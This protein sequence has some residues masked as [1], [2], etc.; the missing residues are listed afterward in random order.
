MSRSIFRL[1][2]TGETAGLRACAGWFQ[3]ISQF[4]TPGRDDMVH[5]LYRDIFR[6]MTAAAL[7]RIAP[8]C[9][10]RTTGLV[11]AFVVCLGS[12]AVASQKQEPRPATQKTDIKA[13]AKTFGKYCAS[14]HGKQGKGDGP[15][16]ATLKIP[17]S[18][19]TVLARTYEGKFPR[20]YVS[21][22]LIF[23]KRVASH[24]SNDMP[25]WGAKFRKIDPEHDRS[26]QKHV[27]DLIAYLESI[28]AK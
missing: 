4:R 2:A 9:F 26:G 12:G 14:C 8:T 25:V 7:S 13:G 19:L 27:D 18:D 17:P 1:P 21:A 5:L 23:G 11:V 3:F 10:G 28:Q 16:A 15:V 24:G 22:V 6:R 20:G